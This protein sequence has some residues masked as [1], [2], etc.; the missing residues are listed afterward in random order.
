MALPLGMLNKLGDIGVARKIGLAAV[1]LLA[2]IVVMMG[3]LRCVYTFQSGPEAVDLL[4]DI[5]DGTIAVI[6]CSLPIYG[7][8]LRREFGST[9]HLPVSQKTPVARVVVLNV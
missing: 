3:A 6:I 9:E 7:A 1:F 5:L 8:L 4:W 2:S